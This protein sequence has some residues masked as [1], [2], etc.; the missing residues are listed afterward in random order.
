MGMFSEPHFE[1]AKAFAPNPGPRSRAR[2]LQRGLQNR[3][4]TGLQQ[5]ARVSNQP[6]DKLVA[7]HC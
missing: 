6:I 5:S 7:S 2:A 4:D 1:A 3:A